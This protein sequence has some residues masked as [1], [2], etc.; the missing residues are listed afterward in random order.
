M[1]NE[2]NFFITS[3]EF[4]IFKFTFII[5]FGQLFKSIMGSVISFPIG[6]FNIY[7]GILLIV[8]LQGLMILYSSLVCF[9]THW[10]IGIIFF[11]LFFGI[12]AYAYI[13]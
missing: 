1:T 12:G 13:F 3:Q 6:S 9:K 2:Y 11:L 5:G 10:Q 4:T 8:F 7:A